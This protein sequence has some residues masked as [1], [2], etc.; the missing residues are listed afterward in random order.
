MKKVKSL[1]KQELASMEIWNNLT[2]E[3]R[4]PIIRLL[5]Q[6]AFKIFKSEKRKNEHKNHFPISTQES[7]D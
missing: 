6:L 2:K 5:A 1:K 4:E 3:Q 7:D